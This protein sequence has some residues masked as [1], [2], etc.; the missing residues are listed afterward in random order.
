MRVVLIGG[1]DLAQQLA[2]YIQT[3][4]SQAE[5]VGFV[6]DF[7]VEGEQRFGIPC[8]GPIAAL[9]DLYAQRQLDAVLL[10]IG[11]NHRETRQQLFEEL[12][13]M[14]PFYTFV[15]P[16]AFIDASATVGEGCCIGPHTVLEQRTIIEPNVFLYGGVN[17]SHDSKIG[18]HTFVAP[19]VAI[20]GF[21]RVGRRCFLGLHSTIVERVNITDDVVIG[22]GALVLRHLTKPGLYM[23]VPVFKR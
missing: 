9:P 14:I 19:S 8:L 4:D 5:V 21:V 3:Y 10:S 23:G 2:H 1:G 6:D 7:A 20:A 13:L 11:Y 15:H 22:A 18:A 12:R 17:V 16:T